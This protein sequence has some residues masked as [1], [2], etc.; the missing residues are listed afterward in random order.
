MN[1]TVHC[2]Y[3]NIPNDTR[4]MIGAYVN[5]RSKEQEEEEEEDAVVKGNSPFLNLPGERKRQE[6]ERRERERERERC[7]RS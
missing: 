2:E 3:A 6:Q 5:K 1:Q 4:K 7:C